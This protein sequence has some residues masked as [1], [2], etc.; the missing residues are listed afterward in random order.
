MSEKT[1]FLVL[2]FCLLGAS[3]SA[4]PVRP[5]ELKTFHLDNWCYSRNQPE[6]LSFFARGLRDGFSNGFH[7]LP[8]STFD[9]AARAALFMTDGRFLVA[10]RNSNGS[11][12]DVVVARYWL[13]GSL[14]T[15]FDTDGIVVA[16]FAAGDAYAHA[17]ALQGSKILITGRRWGFSDYDFGVSRFNSDGSPDTSFNGTGHQQIDLGGNDFSRAIGVDGNNRIVVSGF[18]DAGGNWNY[19]LVR[20]L[21][22]GSPDTAFSGDGQA[23]VGTAGDDF[24]LGQVIEAGNT[25]TIT[26]SY[27]NGNDNFVVLRFGTNGAFLGGAQNDIGGSDDIGWAIAQDASQRFLVAGQAITGTDKD[28]AL[29]RWTSNFTFQGSLTTAITTAD[30]VARAIAITE[31]DEYLL[32]GSSKGATWDFAAARYANTGALIGS[33]GAGGTVTHAIGAGEDLARGLAY[34]NNKMILVGRSNNGTD[35]DMAVARLNSSGSLAASGDGDQNFS[36]DGIN[37]ADF[38]AD[39]DQGQAIA[40]QTDGKYVVAGWRENGNTASRNF[41]LARYLTSGALDTTFGTAGLQNTDFNGDDDE[42]FALSIDSQGRI[43]LAG[44]RENGTAST[45]NFALARY[46]TNGTL[47]TAF[48]TAGLVN[49]DF[50]GDDDEAYAVKHDQTQKIV[51]AGFREN[52]TASSRDF[53]MIRLTTTGALDTAFG[54]GGR[55]VTDFAGDD[56]EVFA[57]AIN[58]NNKILVAGFRENGG[59]NS[60]DWILARYSTGGTLETSVLT[61]VSGGS[62][63]EA[64]ALALDTFGRVYVAGLANNNAAAVRYLSTIA[65]DTSFG[66]SGISTVNTGSNEDAF[67]VLIQAN[68]K[69]VLGGNAGNDI[70]IARLTPSGALDTTWAG[71]GSL[72]TNPGGTDVITGMV[73]ESDGRF[74][75]A[76]YSSNNF[77]IERFWP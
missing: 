9:D 14:D 65:I 15:S 55:V 37:T 43:V 28:F 44:F 35:L 22:D 12:D 71:D 63:D 36:V 70:L 41:A 76:G 3:L 24:G 6:L 27:P 5:S 49:V 75:G 57:I 58:S 31:S 53:A 26:G 7:T 64:Y 39:T 47:D 20:L 32:V 56:D 40:R 54:T 46:R 69:V 29:A 4:D 18:S 33:F 25:V 45:R 42:A 38:S 2:L 13:D 51:A 1:Y 77:F 72:V 16:T 60:R 34:S 30:D 68:G 59:G 52:G 17:I 11:F 10:G 48:G 74:T 67:A 50:A 61:D 21:S 66:T 62:Q 73:L 8:I 23:V 19:A